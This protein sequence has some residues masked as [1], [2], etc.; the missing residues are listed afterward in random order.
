MHNSLQK[1]RNLLIFYL[2]TLP[3]TKITIEIRDR[4]VCYGTKEND[5]DQ[6]RRN[7]QHVR[8][9]LFPG[10]LNKENPSWVKKAA[11][12]SLLRKVFGIQLSIR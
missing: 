8:H 11:Y 7:Q 6:G 10:T 12:D 1:I 4:D 3:K 5:D 9:G 2:L